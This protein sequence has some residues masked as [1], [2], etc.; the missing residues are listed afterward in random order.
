MNIENPEILLTNNF[1]TPLGIGFNFLTLVIE[2][3]TGNFSLD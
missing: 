1:V 2:K 3:N